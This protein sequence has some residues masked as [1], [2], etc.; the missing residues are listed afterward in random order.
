MLEDDSQL[1]I[2]QQWW[3][4][5]IPIPQSSSEA[6]STQGV[7]TS[8]L[9]VARRTR[10]A[11]ISIMSCLQQFNN[12]LMFFLQGV[13]CWNNCAGDMPTFASREAAPHALWGVPV[14]AG[15]TD[16]NHQWPRVL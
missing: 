8:A 11:S 1:T 5:R 2:S 6:G 4:S 3:N 10:H 7:A 12:C 9:M 16:G 13:Y 14:L 15:S